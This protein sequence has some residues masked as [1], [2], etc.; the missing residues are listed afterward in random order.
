MSLVT[1]LLAIF[2]VLL[3]VLGGY[4]VYRFL[5]LRERYS[6]F[7]H[8]SWQKAEAMLRNPEASASDR[9]MAE[10][11]IDHHGDPPTKPKG[12][13]I[14]GAI[15]IWGVAIIFL[16]VSMGLKEVGPGQEGVKTRFGQV[17]EGT[18]TPGLHWLM[19]MVEG[20]TVYDTRVQA[21]NFEDVGGATRDLQPVTLRGLINFHLEKGMAADLLQNVGGPS[22]Y[23]QKV[24]LRPANTA[25]KEV[26][27][28]FNALEVV[29]KRDEIGT[30]TQ[31]RLAERMAPLG[32]IVDRVSV[33]NVA[34][35]PEFLASVE[36]K[37]RAEQDR[38]RAAFEA[39]REVKLAEGDRD[40]QITRAEGDR[41]AR[42][43]RAEGEATANERINESLTDDLLKW[44]A[45]QK[46]NDKVEIML[47]PADQGFII[48][49][50]QVT[51]DDDTDAG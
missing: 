48:D 44:A 49:L 35:N 41:D 17:Q 13:R 37:Q 9:R 12:F 19:P 7:D 28:L 25:L 3:I 36:A 42:I 2:A 50:G 32:I 46:F 45:I 38:D 51:T 31:E 11:W 6:D 40:A 27:P 43:L 20:L 47:V 4:L 8:D 26:T 24:F 30:L 16:I 5:V 21:Y 15:L 39:E 34:L 10:S 33:E 29:S 1:L 23:V 22:E 14:I 18:M